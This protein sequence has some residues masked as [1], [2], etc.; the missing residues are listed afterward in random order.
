MNRSEATAHA[1]DESVTHTE[2]A[3]DKPKHKRRRGNGSLYTSWGGD[4][5]LFFFRWA[6]AEMGFRTHGFTP[7]AEHVGKRQLPFWNELDALSD[8]AKREPRIAALV[9]QLEAI[10]GGAGA[11]PTKGR[12]ARVITQ[13][14]KTTD[15]QLAAARRHRRVAAGMS[16]L[17]AEQPEQYGILGMVFLP[18][19]SLPRVERELKQVV[20]LALWRSLL[21][22]AWR[23]ATAK[24]KDSDCP[25]LEQW[26]EDRIARHDEK[27]KEA[28]EDDLIRRAL[29]DA[30]ELAI[31]AIEAFESVCEPPK[32]VRDEQAAKA[33]KAAGEPKKR[34]SRAPRVVNLGY[35]D[36]AKE[37]S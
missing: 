30:E 20:T 8:R 15:E 18:R 27:R 14:D 24:L 10:A 32:E 33:A 16:R 9:K 22:D 17:R 4:D 1:I 28:G 2:E 21:Q 7:Q 3:K 23:S 37:A 12:A 13:A 11:R 29:D 25:A 6:E 19:R 34:A 26:L 31:K 36:A 5:C 35:E